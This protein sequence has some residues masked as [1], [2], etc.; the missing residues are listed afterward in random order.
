MAKR[1][2]IGKIVNAVGI[3]GEV[4]VYN[5]SGFKDRYENLDRIITDKGEFVIDG[6]RHQQHMIVL[7]LNGVDDRNAAEA[8]KGTVVYMTEDYLMELPDDEFYIRDLI[9]ADV[10]DVA[11]GEKLGKLTDVM[12]DRPQDIYVVDLDKGGRCMIPAVDEFIR[13]IDMKAGRI[14]V[15]LIEGMI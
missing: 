1:I 3:R 7:K 2:T 11:T 5:Y 8:L 14:D 13:S 10:F 12:T 15:A 6:V 9:G 4:K